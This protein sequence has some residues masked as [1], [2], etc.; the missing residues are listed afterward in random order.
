[1]TEKDKTP[2]TLESLRVRIDAIDL[3]IQ[4]LLNERAGSAMQVAKVKK[5]EAVAEGSQIVSFYRPEREA[6]ILK[7]IASRNQGPMRDVHVQRI[8]REIISASLSLE[9]QLKV[10]YLGPAGTYSEEATLRHFGRSVIGVLLGIITLLVKFLCFFF[11]Y[12]FW[13]RYLHKL[14]RCS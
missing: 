6:Q 2:P 10:G 3:E 1:M 12:R 11:L 14:G 9:E 5:A 8:F 4:A 13:Q 7:T